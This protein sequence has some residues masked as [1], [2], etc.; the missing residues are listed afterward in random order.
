MASAPSTASVSPPGTYHLEAFEEVPGLQQRLR[1][2]RPL[3]RRRHHAA[4]QP[5]VQ[6]RDLRDVAEQALRLHLGA[7]GALGPAPVGPAHPTSRLHPH[8][9]GQAPPRPGPAASPGPRRTSH[10]SP[11]SCRFRRQHRNSCGGRGGC[12]GVVPALRPHPDPSSPLP[13][14]PLPG[15]PRH[16]LE[17]TGFTLREK[18]Q[19]PWP[20]P[21]GGK[22]WET[23]LAA[24]PT[25]SSSGALAQPPSLSSEAGAF[26]E[27][28]SPGHMLPQGGTPSTLHPGAYPLCIHI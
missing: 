23:G 5:A 21:P 20:T 17:Q 25:L 9:R 22:P 11:D 10:S 4:P 7:G 12:S 1:A 18:A 14:P 19:A 2:P 26:L 27:P 28:Q 3:Q 8:P 16:S 13:L 24:L 6:P 15:R